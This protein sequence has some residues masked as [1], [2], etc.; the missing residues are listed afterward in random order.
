MKKLGIKT[1]TLALVALFVLPILAIAQPPEDM[2]RMKERIMSMKK[3]KMLDIL[4]LSE[5]KTD[6][7][8][9]KFNPAEKKI[10]EISKSLDE[11]ARDMR[12]LLEEKSVKSGDLKQKSEAILKLQEDL[13]NAIEDKFK[14]VQTVLS[15]EEFA[16]F[17]VFERLFQEELRK[18]LMNRQG[19]DDRPRKPKR[20]R[21]DE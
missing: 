8:L 14:S 3:V 6:K 16:K 21:F 10:M 18:R 4:E 11:N 5:E 17:V 20:D 15:E 13:H 9:A 1:T 7:F 2:G 19:K 12:E